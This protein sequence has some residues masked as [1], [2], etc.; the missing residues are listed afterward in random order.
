MRNKIKKIFIK[1]D[2]ML[3][4]FSSSDLKKIDIIHCFSY[5]YIKSNITVLPVKRIIRFSFVIVYQI[6]IYCDSL[7]QKKEVSN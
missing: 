7:L 3:C 4:I 5:I 6:A 1:I 2:A